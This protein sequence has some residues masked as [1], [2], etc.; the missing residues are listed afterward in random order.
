M[1]KIFK[2]IVEWIEPFKSEIKKNAKENAETIK[3]CEAWKKNLKPGDRC[4]TF[5]INSSIL[6]GLEKISSIRFREIEILEISDDKEFVKISYEYL[7]SATTWLRMS[8]LGII[9]ILSPKVEEEKP[10]K[11]FKKL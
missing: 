8:S 3:L 2:K 7:L 11:K 4:L 10:K 5:F 6:E 9:S 1:K